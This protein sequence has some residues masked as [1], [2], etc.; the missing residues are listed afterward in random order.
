MIRALSFS[1]SLASFLSFV[2]PL[3]WLVLAL[4]QGDQE[5]AFVWFLSIML[6]FP[7]SSWLM[8]KSLE[9]SFHGL[10]L[11]RYSNR[12]IGGIRFIRLGCFV[13]SFCVSKEEKAV[14]VLPMEGQGAWGEAPPAAARAA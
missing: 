3:V 2:F 5:A 13:F 1:I 10:T 12:K 6:F 4:A 8:D 9:L 7:L 11:P 14:R